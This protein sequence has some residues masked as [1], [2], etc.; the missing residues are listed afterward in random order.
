MDALLSTWPFWDCEEL[1]NSAF[2][3]L[4][5]ANIWKA[6]LLLFYHYHH[7]HYHYHYHY[8]HHHHYHYSCYYC[9]HC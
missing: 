7:Y 4:S 5:R 2:Q 9:C 6:N 8:H 3:Q 1:A